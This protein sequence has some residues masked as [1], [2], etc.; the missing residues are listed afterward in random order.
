[1]DG[2]NYDTLIYFVTWD[3]HQ[4]NLCHLH[5]I[6]KDSRGE[7]RVFGSGT[8]SSPD[9][10]PVHLWGASWGAGISLRWLEI[11]EPST[12][13]G[14]KCWSWHGKPRGLFRASTSKTTPIVHQVDILT[15]SYIVHSQTVMASSWADAKISLHFS[16]KN[17]LLDGWCC[18][19]HRQKTVRT[20][21]S[22]TKRWSQISPISVEP[23]VND[24]LHSTQKKHTHTHGTP[25]KKQLTGFEWIVQEGWF[26]PSSH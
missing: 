20:V 14:H 22:F 17:D 11:R 16:E 25:Q 8:K 13:I 26:S 1:M 4:R 24:D 12:Q 5:L 9:F 15:H 6:I 7:M 2:T 18:S 23:T 10:T 19:S 3:S 21:I